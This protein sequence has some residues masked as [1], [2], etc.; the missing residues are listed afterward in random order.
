[1]LGEVASAEQGGSKAAWTTSLFRL[2]AA[3]PEVVAF[4]WFD[5][6]KETDWRVESSASSVRSFRAG[7][8]A[9]R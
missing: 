7:L 3:H 5:L 6:D 2:L 8:A 4:T 1:M 9:R